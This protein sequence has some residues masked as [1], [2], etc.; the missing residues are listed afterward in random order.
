MLTDR[1]LGPE[2]GTE[3]AADESKLDHIEQSYSKL[4]EEARATGL[5]YVV[6]LLEE[7]GLCAMENASEEGSLE[8]LQAIFALL[9]LYIAD[10][11][12]EEQG[13][14]LCAAY[15]ARILAEAIS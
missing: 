2:P 6:C 8:K 5:P 1:L 14:D 12:S 15:F 13:E 7:G 9:A 10:R 3:E 11:V 4:I